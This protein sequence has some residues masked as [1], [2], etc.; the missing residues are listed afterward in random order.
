ME[1]HSI[2]FPNFINEETETNKIRGFDVRIESWNSSV[3]FPFDWEIVPVLLN[4]ETDIICVFWQ[5]LYLI[6]VILSIK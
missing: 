6:V 2:D 5:F 1:S 3:S 4:F